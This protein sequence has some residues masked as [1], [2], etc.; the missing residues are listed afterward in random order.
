[1]MVIHVR[2]GTFRFRR[3]ASGDQKKA[4]QAATIASIANDNVIAPT[5]E[6]GSVSTPAHSRLFE[7]QSQAFSQAVLGILCLD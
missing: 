2:I 3:Q 5:E 7:A 6:T 4:R 1:M